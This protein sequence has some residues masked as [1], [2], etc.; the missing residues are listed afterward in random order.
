[1]P[2]VE[3]DRDGDVTLVLT[4]SSEG[5]QNEEVSILVSSKVLTLAS[6]VFAV[7]L[8]PHF[9]EGQRSASGALSPIPLP[10]DNADAM[11]TLC[12]IL[13]LNNS[14]LPEEPELELFK[15]LALLCDKYDCVKPL[16]F[17]SEYWLLLWTKATI[18]SEMQTLLLISYVFDRPERFSDV[19]MRIIKEFGGSLK[20]LQNLEQFELI[21][22]ELL[23]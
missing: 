9:L 23:R 11:T 3:I 12:H 18:P 5:S 15:N 14:A 10:D 6:R 16:K 4:K 19:S 1:M 2:L 17:V 21:P 13:H 8:G 22:E 7:M 20:H